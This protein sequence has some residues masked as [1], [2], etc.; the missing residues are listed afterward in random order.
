MSPAER[1]RHGDS[2]TDADDQAPESIVP[3]VRFRVASDDEADDESYYAAD[4]SERDF[5]AAIL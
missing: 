4:G 3:T 1:A 2:N 5:H